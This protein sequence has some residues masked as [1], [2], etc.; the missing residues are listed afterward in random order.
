[1]ASSFRPSLAV[2]PIEAVPEQTEL[3][4]AMAAHRMRFEYAKDHEAIF[5]EENFK[6]NIPVEYIDE[7]WTYEAYRAFVEE[8]RQSL[9]SKIG[10]EDYKEA[11]EIDPRRRADEGESFTWTQELV[12]ETMYLYELKLQAMEE[13]SLLAKSACG[14][15]IFIPYTEEEL[16][17]FW[18][19]RWSMTFPLPDGS[20]GRIGPYY[21]LL[22]RP[23]ATQD[24]IAVRQ[25]KWDEL[26]EPY[27]PYGV[28]SVT[29]ENVVRTKMYYQGQ[30][31][32]CIYDE[33][34][35]L[36][37]GERESCPM[38]YPADAIDLC[39]VYDEAGT[40]TGLRVATAEE[41][42]EWTVIRRTIRSEATGG[43]PSDGPEAP[44]L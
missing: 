20:E 14:N 44:N 15:Q 32:R 23:Q 9:E 16:T 39:A 41:M 6:R 30:E 28:T 36:T 35:R 24:Q 1:M 25:A 4:R 43:D 31:V 37:I 42:E 27:E 22:D 26:L 34:R 17:A 13:G 38:Y 11:W 12:D 5:T 3:E 7:W 21:C 8:L 10:T 2:Q 18:E 19:N 40:L 29:P 33:A